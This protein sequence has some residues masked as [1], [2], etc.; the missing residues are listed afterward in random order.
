MEVTLLGYRKVNFSPREGEEIKGTS[1]WL[2][3]PLTGDETA[4]NE[5]DKFF[6]ADVV[7]LPTLKPNTAYTAGFNNKG[8]LASLTAKAPYQAANQTASPS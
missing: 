6:V 2:S 3:W 5:A 7:K 8:K 4:G 1:L